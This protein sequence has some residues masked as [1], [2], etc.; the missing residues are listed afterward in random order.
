M[1]IDLLFIKPLLD[2]AVSTLCKHF[3]VAIGR[4]SDYYRHTLSI[5][6]ELHPSIDLVFELLISAPSCKTYLCLNVSRLHKIETLI[7]SKVDKRNLIW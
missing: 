2:Y 7:L 1:L 6:I 5:T 3:N 4:I